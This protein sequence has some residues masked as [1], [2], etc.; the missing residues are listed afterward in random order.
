MKKVFG[1]FAITGMYETNDKTLICISEY[2][3]VII[4]FKDFL[5]NWW[6]NLEPD[7][8]KEENYQ[9]FF[10]FLSH[11]GNKLKVFRDFL[12]EENHHRISRDLSTG[13]HFIIEEVWSV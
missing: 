4:H 12:F 3:G 9:M 2:D 6:M 8:I 5:E 1:L 13:I 11:Q 10:D 7:F